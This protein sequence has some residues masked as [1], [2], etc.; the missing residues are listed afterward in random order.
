[1]RTRAQKRY[2]A[3]AT[4]EE[5]L[6]VFHPEYEG[7]EFVERAASAAFVAQE[8]RG[9]WMSLGYT[10]PAREC[11]EHWHDSGLA[12]RT[13]LESMIRRD[14]DLWDVIAEVKAHI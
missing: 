3:L 12:D 11:R 9:S 8:P 7:T 2:E 10:A 13:Q 14:F 4:L 6:R 5:W 1:M